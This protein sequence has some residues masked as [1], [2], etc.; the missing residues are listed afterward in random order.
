MFIC[1]LTLRYKNHENLTYIFEF[2]ENFNIETLTCKVAP[3]T[4]KHNNC[5]I[6]NSSSVWC[7]IFII[8]IVFV[9]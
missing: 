3:S 6:Y 8:Y 1:Q 2:C 9:S 5:F 7:Y 4:T